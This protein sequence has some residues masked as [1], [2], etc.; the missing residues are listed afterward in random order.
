MTTS[1]TGIAYIKQFEGYSDY[2]YQC[3]AG[4]WTIGYGHTGSDTTQLGWFDGTNY[5]NPITLEQAEE[6]LRQDLRKFEAA[7]NEAL[8]GIWLNQNQFDA[9]VSFTYNVGADAFK[10][11]TLLKMI[12]SDPM[13][14]SIKAEFAKWV[15]AGGKRNEGLVKRRQKETE[16]YFKKE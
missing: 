8:Y 3:S 7:V 2:V 13:Q 14:W 6:M 11:S 1:D 5:R 12:R 15:N 9:L 4:K 16:L 10:N